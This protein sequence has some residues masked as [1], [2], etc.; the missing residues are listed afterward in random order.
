MGVAAGVYL[1]V[2]LP[3][4]SGYLLALLAGLWV[5]AD[6]ELR[7]PLGLMV[8][9]SSAPYA[10]LLA[11]LDAASDV[12]T[13]ILFFSGV[14]VGSAVVPIIIAG[15]LIDRRSPFVTTGIRI[16]GS[17]IAAAGAMLAAFSLR[18]TGHS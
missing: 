5:A 4:S 18:A 2:R 3:E 6:A 13:P 17:W 16:A 12:K 9:A 8:I 15:T 11:G 10:G 1:P 14:I 7:P